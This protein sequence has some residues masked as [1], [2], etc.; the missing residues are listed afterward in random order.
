MKKFKFSLNIYIF[1]FLF[2]FIQFPITGFSMRPIK[3]PSTGNN[4]KVGWASVNITP[5]KPVI[6][7]GQFHARISEGVMDPVTATALVIES[8]GT[9]GNSEIVV[10]ISCDLVKIA[11]ELRDKV[12]QLVVK[13]I[14]VIQPERII[15]NATH[16]HTAPYCGPQTSLKEVYGVDLPAMTPA[17]CIE[18]VSRR[19]SEAVVKAWNSRKLG[20]I[21][22][23]MSQAVLGHNRLI[24][25]YSG[26]STMYGSTSKPDFSHVE[27]YEDHSVN[28]LYTWDENKKLTGVMINVAVPSQVS[29]QSYLISADFWHDVRTELYQRI[30]PDLFILPQCSAAGDQSPHILIGRKAEERM[31]HITGMDK[32]GK[33]LRMQIATRIAD[34]VTS[35]LP[36]MDEHIEWDPKFSYSFEKAQLSR[37]LM[38]DADLDKA[39]KEARTHEGEYTSLLNEINQ[40]PALKN[41][42]RWYKNLTYEYSRMNRGKVVKQR[43]EL[44]RINPKMEVELHVIRI[45][46]IA[47]ATNPYE[48]YLDYGMRIKGRSPAIQ[49]FLVQLAGP[50]T[51]LPPQRSI[52]GGSYGAEAAS[53][54]IG[55]EGG[56]ELVEKT[57]EMIDH[58]WKE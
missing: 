31:Q 26:N 30:S 35:V 23:G 38:N 45:G 10:L 22:Y 39:L 58:L 1:T 33:G 2:L 17:E 20:G 52:T 6:L 57:L 43:H 12:R 24:V 55:P 11:N 28:L 42:P 19:I 36:Y 44:E 46:D 47:I 32:E 18:F 7:A 40:N 27:G 34:A 9:A 54:N 50:G 16:T 8:T 29:E 51:Y 3:E 41:E 21:S 53:T 13:D 14:P 56:K 25:Y 37:R 48:L 49:T 15:L 4:F 5:D